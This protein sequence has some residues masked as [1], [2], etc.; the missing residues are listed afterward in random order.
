MVAAIL[1][2]EQFA[3]RRQLGR[4]ICDEFGFTDRLG[5]LQVAGCLKALRALERRSERIVLPPAG[6]PVPGGGRPSLLADEGCRLVES[7]PQRLAE[8]RGLRVIPVTSTRQRRIWNTLIHNEHR[9]GITTFA[10]A[11]MRY[12]VE[13]APGWLGALGFA[14]AALRLAARERWMAWSDQQRRA[15]LDR[16]VGLSRFLIRAG[17]RNLAS[18]VLGQ[19]LRRLPQDFEQRYGYRPWLV[20]SFVSDDQPGTSLRA[21]NFVPIGT[22]AG[23][24]RQD[25]RHE[26]K[27]GV[28]TVYMYALRADWRERLGVPPVAA[29]PRREPGQG[30]DAGVWA[31]NEFGGAMLGDKRLTDR[32][33]R[34]ADLLAEVPGR[35]IS[36]NPRSNAAAVDGYYRLIE[37]SEKNSK[38][39]ARSILAPHR[40]RTVQRMRSQ[41]LV[42]CIQDGSDLRFPTRPACSGLEVIGRNQTASKTKGLHLHLT[43]AVTRQGLPLGVLRCGF[44]TPPKA[45]G[46]KSRRW[47]DGYRDIAAAGRDLTRKTRLVAVM[48]REA[49]FYALFDEQQDNGR[50]EV[51]VRAKHD[52]N[53]DRQGRKLFATMAGGEADGQLRIAVEGL[54]ERPK[55]SRKKARPARQKR[56][57]LCELRYRQLELP[58]TVKGGAAVPLAVVHVVELDPP[59]D[60]QPVQWHLLTSQRVRAPEEAQ[61][62]VG[63]YLQ[64][65]KVEDYFRVLK[66]GCGTQ[67]MGFRTAQRMQRA[68]AIHSVIA[69][70]LMVMTLLGRQVP[71]CDPGLLYTEAELGFLRD[72][73]RQHGQPC[74]DQLGK[75]A[76]LVAHLGGYRGRKH[77]AIF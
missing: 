4:R 45:Q 14:A 21:A 46:G 75:A 16:V 67:R 42:L 37:R 30:L 65:W 55:S 34:S 26:G 51:L 73:A 7:V 18:H 60:E 15:H 77:R 70:R 52:R 69:W 56:L 47:I 24:G 61:E 1:S 36:A 17:C 44:G 2:S 8:V 66:T 54:V 43:L 74:P 57:A 9:Q 19:V 5:R 3:S 35:S 76:R 28:K 33:V 39:T 64:R 59:G 22:T 10:G 58:A 72:Y 38:V 62:V 53:L 32:L 6:P 11:Q 29:R 25:R 40:E 31:R 63:Q 27:A 12:L 23:R 48:D 71:D 20:E 13:S 68:V 41:D 50:V 49:D